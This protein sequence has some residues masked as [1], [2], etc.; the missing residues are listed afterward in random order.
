MKR[1][2][3]VY[4]KFPEREDEY[5][6]K[7]YIMQQDF[8]KKEFEFSIIVKPNIIEKIEYVSEEQQDQ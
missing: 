7:A 4:V 1:F 2:R 5:K 6:V 8:P 3:K